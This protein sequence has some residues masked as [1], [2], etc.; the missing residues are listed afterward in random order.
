MEQ[1]LLEAVLKYM[2]AREVIQDSQHNC[3]K[4]KSCPTNLVAFCDG[5]TTSVVKG[6]AMDVV[7]QDSCKAFDMVSHNIL[8]SKLGRYRFDGWTLWW[9][10]N[11]LDGRSQRAVVNGS[12][13]KWRSVKSGVPQVSVL[14]QV[15][16]NIFISDIYSEIKYTLSKFAD[17]TK[18]NGAVDTPEG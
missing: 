13:S 1:I 11:W 17:N 8:L 7:C 6:R 10:R 2:E 15:L 3:T 5:V 18:M 16:F 9:I 4:G 12:M 14:G